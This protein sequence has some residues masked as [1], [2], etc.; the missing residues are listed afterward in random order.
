MHNEQMKHNE[1]SSSGSMI[2]PTLETFSKY[3][4]DYLNKQKS[5]MKVENSN[6]DSESLKWNSKDE[7]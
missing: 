2:V 7:S 6:N 1:Q 3:Y 5:G 4:L